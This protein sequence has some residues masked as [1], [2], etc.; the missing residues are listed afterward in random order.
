MIN[1]N[2]SNSKNMLI[3]SGIFRGGVYITSPNQILTYSDINGIVT[4]YFYTGE[5]PY[6]TSKDTPQADSPFW[7]PMFISDKNSY[8]KTDIVPIT[9]GGTG[10][11]NNVDARV[12][13]DV[14]SKAETNKAINKF[15]LPAINN[16][17]N[18]YYKIATLKD[19][20]VSAG[21]V[22]ISISGANGIGTATKV[23]DYISLS[24]RNISTITTA[25]GNTFFSHTRLYQ[26]SNSPLRVGYVIN[27]DASVDVYLNSPTGYW[28]GATVTITSIAGSGSSVNGVVSTLDTTSTSWVV[29]TPAGYTEIDVANFYTTREIIPITNGGTGA[30]DASNAR[31]NL[32]LGT[33]ATVNIGTSGSTI[34]LLNTINTWSANQLHSSEIINSNPNIIRGISPTYGFILRNDGTST[35]M[36]LTDSGSASGGWNSLRPFA[37]N[38]SNGLVTIGN[39]ITISG[40]TTLTTPLGLSNGG[41][42]A[43]N[44]TTARTNLDVYSKAE[45]TK[46][47]NKIVLPNNGSGTFYYKVATLTDSGTNPGYV[48]F[49]L[50]GANNYGSSVKNYD[51]ITLS[52][53]GISTITTGTAN[54]FFSHNRI[55]LQSG[56]AA[57]LGYVINV[58][59]T[60]DVYLV[61]NGGYWN[62]ATIN[63]SSMIGGGSVITGVLN[64]LNPAD[65]SWSSTLPDNFNY[66]TVYDILT[67]NTTVS[68]ANGGTGATSASA[69]RSNLGLGTSSTINTGTSG[70]TIPL[71]STVNTWSSSQTF[72]DNI[73][74]ANTK[75]ILLTTTTSTQQ[76]GISIDNTNNINIGSINNPLIL[77]SS[78]NPTVKV[79]ANTYTLYST[80]NKPTVNAFRASYLTTAGSDSKQ[81]LTASNTPQTLLVNT[82]TAASSIITAN[83]STG[84]FLCNVTQ[85]MMMSINA[86]II[87]ETTGGGDVYWIMF[88]ETSTDGT[89]WTPVQGSNR[90][91]TL[92]SSTTN[93]MKQVDFTVAIQ[94]TQGSYIRIRHACTDSTK[95]ISVISKDSLFAGVPISSGL[96]VSFLTI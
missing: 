22:N 53:R 84:T 28:T 75:G 54:N 17:S 19:S 6:T 52:A 51:Y 73:I 78:I 8:L 49:V 30:S 76:N 25:N 60:V 59:L 62:G 13:L 24:A 41:T 86:Q 67:T 9:S 39:G 1:L 4:G 18:N 96:I 61:C 82:I 80:G 31:T 93:E 48:Q 29:S 35:Y 95:A 55:N 26:V 20:G 70:A 65:A 7:K 90:I 71:L 33:S 12:N 47:I 69:A 42:G 77:N 34:P 63:I 58:D 88:L 14:Y 72:N 85:G 38:N 2:S 83:T 89:T 74:T 92:S 40:S 64:T 36:L 32:G 23:L 45:T 81:T 94:S 27:A 3:N 87:R 37:I 5:L 56:S 68:I 16:N 43:N 46:A 91:V 15:V 10:S 11:N 79:G 21:Y 44:I 66:V 57:R 50:T